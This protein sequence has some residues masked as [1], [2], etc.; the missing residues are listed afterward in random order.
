MYVVAHNG[1]AIFGGGELAVVRLLQG[2]QGRGHRVLLLCR[3]AIVAGRVEDFGVPA[4]V[5]RVGGDLALPDAFRLAGRLRHERP[6]VVLLTTFKKVLLAGLGARIAGVPRVV[7]RI[8]LES[9]T[10]ARGR[11]YRW[12]YRNLVDDVVVNARSMRAPFLAAAPGLDPARVSVIPQGVVEPRRRCEPGALR[13][14]LGIP[15]GAPVFGAVARLARQKRLDRLIAALSHLP[16]EVHCVVAGAGEEEDALRALAARS[17]VADRFHLAGH[18]DDVGDVLDALD[19]YV[20]C[21]DREGMCNAMLEAMAFGLPVVSTPVSGAEEALRPFIDGTRP[22]RVVGFGEG[23]LPAALR[24]LLADV[25][26]RRAMGDAA[27]RR[28]EASFGFDA[29]VLR[30]EALL[31]GTAPAWDRPARRVAADAMAGIGV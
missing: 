25:D 1:S 27:R 15:A 7:Q 8:G 19:A 16:N 23:E 30:W 12:A 21:S 18:R 4:G 17:G 9:D 11:R 29:M 6:D 2:L 10:P 3:D 22:G 14:E 28:A 24:D 26:V 5:Q 20:V 13:R 31:G